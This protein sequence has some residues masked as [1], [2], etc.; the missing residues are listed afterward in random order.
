MYKKRE[1]HLLAAMMGRASR[2]MMFRFERELEPL[3]ITPVEGTILGMLRQRGSVSLGELARMWDVN[4]S[5]MSRTVER[6]VKVGLVDRTPDLEDRRRTVL[7]TTVAGEEVSEKVTVIGGR[8]SD[9][10]VACL[11]SEEVERLW[12]YLERI[13]DGLSEESQTSQSEKEET[14]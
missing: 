10:M 12:D 11:G 9:D 3:G 2:R 13:L 1:R 4:P 6:L 14:R 7:V 8:I 5:M